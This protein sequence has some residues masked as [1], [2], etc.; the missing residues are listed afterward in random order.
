MSNPDV[1][2]DKGKERLEV[3]NDTTKW[4]GGKC[5]SKVKAFPRAPTFSWVF[6]FH[7]LFL[8]YRGVVYLTA[9]Q[10]AMPPPSALTNFIGYSNAICN[11]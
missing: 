8:T 10:L 2:T 11:A 3:K 4:I 9:G 1:A 6:C 5:G 7:T